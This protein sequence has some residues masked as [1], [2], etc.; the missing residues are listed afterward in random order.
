MTPLHRIS[1]LLILALGLGSASLHAE[2][3]HHQPGLLEVGA[4][5]AH[6]KVTHDEAAGSISVAVLGPDGVTPLAIADAPRLNLTVDGK[7]S[8]V[9]TTAVT[10]DAA[11]KASTFTATHAALKGHVEGHI[12][13]KIDGASYQVALPHADHEGHD[14]HEGHDH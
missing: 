8:Q 3:E 5:A 10:P 14:E 6:L 13:I 12:R 11:G 9:K 4:H 7:H 1:L 2:E